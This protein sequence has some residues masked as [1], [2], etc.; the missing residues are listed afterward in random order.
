[1]PLVGDL[2]WVGL[3]VPSIL[4][5]ATCSALLE[6]NIASS[7]PSGQGSILPNFLVGILNLQCFKWV[8]FK[9]SCLP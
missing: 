7:I 3:N 6:R 5:V 8:E 9:L 2:W 1:M 4:L